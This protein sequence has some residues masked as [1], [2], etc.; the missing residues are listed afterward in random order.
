M[1]IST[2]AHWILLPYML[3][4]NLCAVVGLHLPY[5][6]LLEFILFTDA[7]PTNVDVSVTLHVPLMN[8]P[9]APQM[10]ESLLPLLFLCFSL[11]AVWRIWPCFHRHGSW[12]GSTLP[13]SVI[14]AGATPGCLG[15]LMLFSTTTYGH[16]LLLNAL[17]TM[18]IMLIQDYVK[19][20]IS[21]PLRPLRLKRTAVIKDIY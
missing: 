10:A 6:I 1:D 13:A 3:S 19:V 15:P 20:N 2:D 5:L 9:R 21:T 16:H 12:A 18:S 14:M 17:F 11:V 7:S 8:D 4:Q